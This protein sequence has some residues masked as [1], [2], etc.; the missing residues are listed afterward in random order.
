MRHRVLLQAAV[1]AMVLG[2]TQPRAEENYPAA[3]FEPEVI[4]QDSELIES[5]GPLPVE[6]PKAAQAAVKQTPVT[7]E[8]TGHA[9]P[10]GTVTDSSPPYGML[11]LALIIIGLPFLLSMR[12]E[13]SKPVEEAAPEPAD[14]P[15]AASE[16][17]ESGASEE[18]EEA[19]EALAEEV[20]ETMATSNRQRANKTKRARRR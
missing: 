5:V 12:E 11:L 14:E 13:K 6:S 20:E 9:K 2:S 1:A 10:S 8:L 7:R 18:A 15:E 4:F 16:S 17:S 3:N 19:L